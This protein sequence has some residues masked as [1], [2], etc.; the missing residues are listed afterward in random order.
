MRS[1]ILGVVVSGLA[2]NAVGQC[3][4]QLRQ[5]SAHGTGNNLVVRYYNSGTKTIK[6]VQFTLG[7]PDAG[8]SRQSTVASYGAGDT[9]SPKHERSAFFKSDA[10]TS[11]FSGETLLFQ[12]KS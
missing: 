2:V 10:Q 9:L 3:P 7:V 1:L 12:R 11:S 6:A 4:I 5:A 8:P